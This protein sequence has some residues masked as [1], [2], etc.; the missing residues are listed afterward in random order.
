MI[1]NR[2]L[3]VCFMTLML[4]LAAALDVGASGGGYTTMGNPLAR[5]Q[6]EM[7]SRQL[8][9][10]APM[11]AALVGRPEHGPF[12]LIVI[13]A[14]GSQ[15]SSLILRETHSTDGSRLYRLSVPDRVA[16]RAEA[17]TLFVESAEK[18]EVLAEYKA[19]SWILHTPEEFA[20]PLEPFV[21]PI[22]NELYAFPVTTLGPF[23]LLRDDDEYTAAHSGNVP[24]RDVPVAR[25]L[26]GIMN[27]ISPVI[28]MLVVFGVSRLFHSAMRQYED[29][30]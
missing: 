6:G 8:V 30:K 29:Q 11:G 15:R 27:I 20:G 14:P 7:H 10:L 13:E 4:L 5:A 21:S 9:E 18:H 19:N 28:F 12:R 3:N 26:L 1:L 22:A 16:E 24:A 23:R 25:V 2:L 17:I